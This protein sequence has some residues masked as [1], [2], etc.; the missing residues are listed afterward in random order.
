MFSLSVVQELQNCVHNC[1][2]AVGPT[3]DQPPGVFELAVADQ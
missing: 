3:H 2:T 1:C